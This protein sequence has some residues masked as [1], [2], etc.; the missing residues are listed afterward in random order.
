MNIK[1]QHQKYN[2]M[3]LTSPTTQP[4]ERADVLGNVPTVTSVAVTCDGDGPHPGPH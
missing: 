1:F 3:K 4:V 2:I